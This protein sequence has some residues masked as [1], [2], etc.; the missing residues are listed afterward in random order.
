MLELVVRV[1]IYMNCKKFG[2]ILFWTFCK[3]PKP[4]PKAGDITVE[5]VYSS[6]SVKHVDD[7]IDQESRARTSMGA[8]RNRLEHAYTNNANTSENKYTGSR[9]TTQRYRYG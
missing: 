5:T 8:I 9:I 4:Q 7:A 3:N 6:D 1:N 2:T